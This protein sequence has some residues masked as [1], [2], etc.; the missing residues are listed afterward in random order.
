MF[1]FS[2]MFSG[3]RN[4]ERSKSQMTIYVYSSDGFSCI[5]CGKEGKLK[6][7][8][9]KRVCGSG[10]SVLC[11]AQTFGRKSRVLM[12]CSRHM[13]YVFVPILMAT[14]T[15][16]M[17]WTRNQNNYICKFCGINSCFRLN[18][19]GCAVLGFFFSAAKH[20]KNGVHVL[21]TRSWEYQNFNCLKIN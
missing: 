8:S 15:R 21:G 5:N 19:I 17:I 4:N 11:T 1:L 14:P 7:S 2:A 16:I 6:E 9:W 20:P 12:N 13:F 3:W 18:I 10:G